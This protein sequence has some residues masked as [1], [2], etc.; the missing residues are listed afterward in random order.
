MKKLIFSFV[1]FLFITGITN[2]QVVVTTTPS[3]SVTTCV[4]DALNLTANATGG[5]GP[6]TF[7]WIPATNL[8]SASIPNP[9]FSAGTPGTYNYQVVATDALGEDDTVDLAITVNPN[10]TVGIT[11]NPTIICPG[12]T[13]ALTGT[14]AM[15]YQWSACGPQNPCLVSPVATTTYT[16]TG[17]LNGCSS[18]AFV[19]ITVASPIQVNISSSSPGNVIYTCVDTCTVLTANVTGGIPPYTYFWN[20]GVASQNAT[21][22]YPIAGT[23][24]VSLSVTDS[25]GCM[26]SGGTNIVAYEC[27]DNILNVK[28]FYDIDGNGI[29]DVGENFIGAGMPD[30][31]APYNSVHYFPNQGWVFD[32]GPNTYNVTPSSA[33]YVQTSNPQVVIT[34]TGTYNNYDLGVQMLPGTVEMEV[35]FAG[36]PPARPGFNVTY[37]VIYRNNGNDTLSNVINFTADPL[38]TVS[39]VWSNLSLPGDTL[40]SVAG[41]QISWNYSDLLPFEVRNFYVQLQLSSSVTLGTT[42]NHSVFAVADPGEVFLMNNFDTLTGV[43]VGAFDPNEKS[44]QPYGPITPEQVLA[45]QTLEYTIHFQNV[46]T[47]MATTVKVEDALSTKLDQSSFEFVMSSHPCSLSYTNGLLECTF[48]NINLPDSASDPEGSQGF[49]IYRIKPLTTLQIGDSIT[50]TANIYFDFNPAVVTN[51]T[52]TKVLAAPSGIEDNLMLSDRISVYPN[53]FSDQT[54]LLL[55]PETQYPCTLSMCDPLGRE[56]LKMEKITDS[57][58]IISRKG[59]PGGMYMI[60]IADSKQKDIGS[61]KVLIK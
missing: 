47:Y 23:L 61:I 24:I 5:T 18:T 48:N 6:Y 10:P 8:S 9:V 58:I 29:K 45:A 16:V 32:V 25:Q 41:N 57:K 38:F 30:I 20:N 28:Y 14:G 33:S 55:P 35:L 40:I 42:Y 43:V 46:G 56:V 19:V 1:I 52:V 17:T 51:T 39:N 3:V 27:Q 44:V 36:A 2:A 21:F 4:G 11:A 34:G 53:P 12:M 31:S 60:R 49:V 22:C 37:E 7:E 15:T 50:N 13:V 54:T 59:M 26:G